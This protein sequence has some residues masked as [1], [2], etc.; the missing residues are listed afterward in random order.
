MRSVDEEF[1]IIQLSL[2]PSYIHSYPLELLSTEVH[3][4]FSLLSEIELEEIQEERAEA[5]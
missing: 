5:K 2:L 3:V 4:T 1:T